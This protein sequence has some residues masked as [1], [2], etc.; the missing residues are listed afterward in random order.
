METEVV[1]ENFSHL[2]F[3]RLETDSFVQRQYCSQ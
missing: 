1:R 2:A 3:F